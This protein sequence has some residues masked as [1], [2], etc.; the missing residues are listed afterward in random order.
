M[1]NYEDIDDVIE[2]WHTGDAQCSLPEFLG[3]TEAEY[4]IFVENTYGEQAVYN[5]ISE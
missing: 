5:D 1:I 2:Q 4:A 3:L